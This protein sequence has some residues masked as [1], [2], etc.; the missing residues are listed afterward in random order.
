M[1]EEKIVCPFCKGKGKM[2]VEKGTLKEL[3]KAIGL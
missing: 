3:K 2:I 1:V